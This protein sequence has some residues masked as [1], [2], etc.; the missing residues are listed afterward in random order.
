VRS[1]SAFLGVAAATALSGASFSAL[2][3]VCPST[4]VLSTY[5]SGGAHA[6]CTVLD[7]TISGMTLTDV[8]PSSFIEPSFFPGVEP[9]LTTNNP[10][11]S[12]QSM[13]SAIGTGP[14]TFTI[15]YTITAPSNRPIT[16]A[17]LAISAELF[18]TI[19][20]SFQISEMLS[21][22]KSISASNSVLTDSIT[23]APTMS[24][25]VTDS[26]TLTL[27][28]LSSVTNQF[29][30]TAIPEPSSLILLG[31]GLSALGLIPRRKRS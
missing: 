18:P 17:S 15:T 12:F 20:A 3:A 1:K 23:F 4:A 22:G 11:L 30:Q 9:I 2:A 8:A 14:N 27:G 26:G 19:G 21:N 25:T 10:G 6:G 5:F 16:D 7:K 28:I 31:V 29:S 24:L 13:G